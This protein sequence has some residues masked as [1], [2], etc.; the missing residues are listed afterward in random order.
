MEETASDPKTL[1]QN[2]ETLPLFRCERTHGCVSATLRRLNM[3]TNIMS[4]ACIMPERCRK[5]SLIAHVEKSRPE[6]SNV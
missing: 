2:S 5:Y 4:F 1:Y 3:P 6:E